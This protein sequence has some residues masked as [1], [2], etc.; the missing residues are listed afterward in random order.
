MG[1]FERILSINFTTIIDISLYNKLNIK[2]IRFQDVTPQTIAEKILSAHSVDSRQVYAGDRVDVNPSG[3]LSNEM[4]PMVSIAKFMH[5]G[6]K[7]VH[8]IFKRNTLVILDHGGFGTTD[9]MIDLHQLTLNFAKQHGIRVEPAGAGISHVVFHE[10]GMVKSGDLILGTDSH[11]VT[12]GGFNAFA[13]GIGGSDLVE[14]M[15]KG[16][17]WLDVPETIRVNV[18]GKLNKGVYSKDL[19]LTMLGENSTEWGTDRCFEFVGEGILDLS[20]E[21]RLTM[22]NMAVEMGGVAGIMPHDDKLQ[23]YLETRPLR[24]QPKPT[25]SDN[26]AT[27]YQEY[28]INASEV[29]PVVACPPS[30]DNVKPVSEVGDVELDQVFIGSCTNARIE[31]LEIMAKIMKGKKVSTQTI[32]IPGS[33]AVALQAAKRGY[34]EIFMEAGAYWSYSTCGACYGG[35][36]GRVGPGMTALSTTNRNFIGRMGGDSTSKTYLG[37]PATAAASAIAGRIVSPEELI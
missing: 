36:L 31:D 32:V 4:L 37:S 35:S 27:F 22:S 6:S 8:D 24:G 21:A 10:K 30:P 29:V 26:G 1:S 15:V 17:T 13:K 3:I 25:A 18:T 23:R 16:S 28:E 19:L 7:H 12:H 34:V 9:K 5:T 2:F 11:T 14:L 20:L 33:S